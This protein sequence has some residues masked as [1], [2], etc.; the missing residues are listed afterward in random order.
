M[1]LRDRD[2]RTCLLTAAAPH[3]QPPPEDDDRWHFATA[4]RGRG[5]CSPLPLHT[6]NHHPKMMIDGTSRPR[7]ADGLSGGLRRAASRP[8]AEKHAETGAPDGCPVPSRSA[9]P[10]HSRIPH[11][12]TTSVRLSPFPRPSS[13]SRRSSAAPRG[14]P[15]SMHCRAETEASNPRRVFREAPLS[16]ALQ[17][18][19][20]Q[21]HGSSHQAHMSSTLVCGQKEVFGAS[22]APR[23][24]HRDAS[25]LAA[26]ASSSGEEPRPVRPA[27]HV[28]RRRSTG[29]RDS[30]GAGWSR[31]G[32][33]CQHRRHVCESRTGSKRFLHPNESCGIQTPSHGVFC[34]STLTEAGSDLHQDCLTWLCC[35]FRFSQPL[36]ALFRP[37]PFQPCFMPV[38]PSSFRFQRFP[39]PGSGSRLSAPP[40]LRAVS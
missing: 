2:S 36:D 35:A 34:S 6:A 4:T 28:A 17:L 25:S 14:A 5:V 31:V 26:N 22:P 16:A 19:P 24:R 40:S 38:T 18:Q 12:T 30:F 15:R 32:H 1:A 21:G 10:G 7:L 29:S 23:C 27:C 8:G 11:H 33:E 9:S 20:E 37:Q 39:L 3:R 13:Q